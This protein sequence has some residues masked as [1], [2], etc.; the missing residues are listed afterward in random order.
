MK[1]LYLDIGNSFLKLAAL[2]DGQWKLIFDERLSRLEGLTEAIRSVKGKPE[3]NVSSVRKD[4]LSSLKKQLSDYEIIHHTTS[5][6]PAGYLDYKTP[7]TFGFDRYLVCLGAHKETGGDVVVTDAGSACTVDVMTREGIYKGGIIMPGLDLLNK[8]IKSYLPE[9]PV[10]GS[11]LPVSF[12][13]KSTI[14]CL[15]WGV[16]G[17][18]IAALEGFYGRY[19][20]LYPEASLFVTGGDA[21]TVA[22]WISG[23]FT[24]SVNKNL[25]WEGMKAFAEVRPKRS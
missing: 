17:G 11:N 23:E 18:F 13:G 16:N 14:E 4:V 20:K 6:I 8:T 9:L 19:L 7:G 5:D 25:I 2:V 24:L 1:S 3:L 21:S 22:G 10:T 12:P 15:E